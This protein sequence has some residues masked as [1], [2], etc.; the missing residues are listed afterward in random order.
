MFSLITLRQ[1]LFDC[2]YISDA[3]SGHVPSVS[4]ASDIILKFWLCIGNIP[5][6]STVYDMYLF[7]I[8]VRY[9]HI[10]FWN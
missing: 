6:W 4:D 8:H 2:K 7:L 5:T 3:Y 1:M 9:D 10:N